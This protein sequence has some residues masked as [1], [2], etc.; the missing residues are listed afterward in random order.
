MLVPQRGVIRDYMGSASIFALT[1]DD[2]VESR[3]ITV[4]RTMGDKWLVTSGVAPGD[5][6]IVEGLQ[7]IR[8]GVTVRIAGDLSAEKPASEAK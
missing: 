5:R 8:P 1:A 4:A 3:N 2:K 7:R 6:V